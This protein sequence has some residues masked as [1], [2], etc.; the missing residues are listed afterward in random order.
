VK[1]ENDNYK[2]ENDHIKQALNNLQTHYDHN[3]EENKRSKII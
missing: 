2:C 1:N 3:T